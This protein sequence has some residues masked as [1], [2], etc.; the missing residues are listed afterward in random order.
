MRWEFYNKEKFQCPECLQYRFNRMVNENGE[1]YPDEVGRCDRE[2]TCGYMYHASEWLQDNPISINPFKSKKVE[3]APKQIIDGYYSFSEGVL[4]DIR[5]YDKEHVDKFKSYFNYSS[6]FVDFLINELHFTEE[7]IEHKMNEYR[8]SYTTEMFDS[9]DC[10][11]YHGRSCVKYFYVSYSQEIRAIEKIYYEGFKRSKYWPNEILN[12]KYHC[13]GVNKSYDINTTEINWCLFGEHLIS[14]H[15]EKPVI[16]VE[17]VKT[18]FGMSLYYPEYNWVA[19]GSS[20]RLIHLNFKTEYKVHFIPD[21]GMVRDKSYT[22]IWKDKIQKIYGVKFEYEVLDFNEYCS[23]DE[24]KD[25][26]DILD[27]QLKEPERVKGIL[28]TIF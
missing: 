26:F 23:S 12:K 16:V 13:R 25:G 21:S 19:T 28:G 20:N 10:K 4:K 2:N 8:M 17:G 22:Q 9:E 14:E 7:F 1:F 27:V 6:E 3:I 15:P 18:A 24:I 5:R 11:T